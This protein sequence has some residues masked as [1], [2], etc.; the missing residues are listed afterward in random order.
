MSYLSRLFSTHSLKFLLLLVCAMLAAAAIWFL[1][2]FSGFGN[3][4]PL[5]SVSARVLCIAVIWLW[6]ARLWWRIPFFIPLAV[7]TS[8][9]TWVIGPWLLAGKSYPLASASRRLAIILVI[10]LV[11]LLFAAWLLMLALIRNPA[12]FQR[13]T[14]LNRK[15]EQES[16]LFAEISQQIRHAVS[17]TN[18][19]R[20]HWKRWWTALL[21]SV[22]SETVPWYLVL[23]SEG[24]GK[25]AMIAT[26]GQDFPLPEQL[27]RVA[28]ENAP[29]RHCECWFGNDAMYLDTAG[30]YISDDATALQEWRHLLK[31]LHK[32]RNRD[33][34]N[35]AIVT[36]S[37]AEILEND[38]GSVLLLATRI[39]ARLDEL[40]QTLGVH[41]PVYVVVTCLDQLSGFEPWFRSM[42]HEAREQVWGVTFPWGSMVYTATGD[43]QT[44]INGELDALQKRLASGIHPRQQE[45][46]SLYERKKMYAFPLDFQL[47]CT[48]VA[49]F[50]QQTFFSSRYDETQFCASF[51]GVYFSSSCQY[52]DAALL[53]QSAV[54]P[55]WEN[56]FSPEKRSAAAC[57]MTTVEQPEPRHPR[58][59]WGK[60]FFLKQLF[61]DVIVKDAGLVTRNFR[62]EARYRGQRLLAHVA[63]IIAAILLIK[64]IAISF[65]NNDRFLE[66]VADS[67]RQLASSVSSLKHFP[68]D[69]TLPRLLAMARQL[70]EF[71]DLD[72]PVPPLSY[73]YGLYT[74]GDVQRH[75]NGLYQFMLKKFLLPSVQGEATSSLIAGLQSE[76]DVKLYHALKIYLGVYGS[77]K[78]NKTWLVDAITQQ[79]AAADK[80]NGY[81]DDTP[82]DLHL[83][84]MFE[85]PDWLQYGQK[86][87][88][89]LIKQARDVLGHHSLSARLYER[90]KAQQ[91]AHAPEALTLD[92]L[93]GDTYGQIFTLSDASL[94]QEGIP[95][96]F[97]KAGYQML[98]KKKFLYLVSELEQEDAWV[99]G[100]EKASGNVL[101][102]REGVLKLYLREYAA[103]WV[104][105]LD[106]VHLITLAPS[107]QGSDS[108][109]A[110][111]IYLLKILSAPDS[112]L[113]NLAREA[114]EQTTLTQEG[115]RI[116]P[117]SR[118]LTAVRSNRLLNQVTKWNGI[119]DN[120]I[121]KI[122]ASEVDN[123]FRAL[124]EFV[125]GQAMMQDGDSTSANLPGS[126]LNKLSAM[127]SELYTLFVVTN[128]SF[129]NGDAP[130]MPDT[131]KRMGIQAQTWPSPFRTIIEP[132]LT[133]ATQKVE[134]QSVAN[135][136][137]NINGSLGEICRDT[138]EN[139]YPFADSDQEVNR[140]DFERFFA[141][142]G[143]VDSWFKQN[144]ADKVDMSQ[145]V[146]RYK[147]TD[148][149]GNLA[150]FQQVAQI[151]NA[152]F[153]GEDGQKMALTP[154]L[155][156]VNLD[157]AIVQLNMNLSG[158]IFHYI[159]GP[160]VPWLF[161]WP[162]ESGAAVFN[163][164]AQPAS[165]DDG[166]RIALT[167]TWALFHWL[168][169]AV[170]QR[171][172]SDGNLLLTF[173]LGKRRMDIE[174]TGLIADNKALPVLL[175]EF[176]CP[177]S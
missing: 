141:R 65:G 96:L 106:S 69:T 159:H 100:T 114:A 25:T 2:P 171:V 76:D 33:G 116:L 132:F 161:D 58:V 122:T 42:T 156:V 149:E 151:R 64:G 169:S 62:E 137:H 117:D 95:G 146:W 45:E 164:D 75:A 52:A 172:L 22:M 162:A 60:N 152:F 127:L 160:V 78:A 139:R 35:G 150:F 63:L 49:D 175:R 105:L 174:V 28:R 17:L 83:R 166:S 43:L 32:Y 12:L 67:S 20:N 81:S 128:N 101:A 46:Y 165:R 131:G 148:N 90:V 80:L 7:T 54:I 125:N 15:P 144:L 10:W 51:R 4:R 167:G 112:P 120:A 24:V 99:M 66:A 173:S 143:L 108:P 119:A 113:V 1:G 37:A 84:A 82:F 111:D 50:L 154:G 85:L 21:P 14:S 40:R 115:Q 157:P 129:A 138:L 147:G 86:P 59:V 73:R 109:L 140:R 104:H 177:A 9:L 8:V 5:A 130:V 68:D 103:Y 123:R 6:L 97:T 145:P 102:V 39:R 155:S 98:V 57:R 142:D 61:A 176:H 88:D 11:T 110:S 19:V 18:R 134:I 55:R 158:Q 87:D 71:E 23:G 121:K 48:G 41:F 89:A 44:K 91:M 124:R 163:I 170:Q 135:N 38:K 13:F 118:D 53:N 56:Y 136:T 27:S 30:K 126:Q 36:V 79:W 34:I 29:T 107:A 47:L 77:A 70:P 3:V 16:L 26:S 74:G 153:N 72:L 31:V 92:K 93:T 168:D 94:A 133:D